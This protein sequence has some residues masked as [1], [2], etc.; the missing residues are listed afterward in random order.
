M[1]TTAALLLSLLTTSSSLGCD[2]LPPEHSPYGPSLDPGP[3]TPPSSTEGTIGIYVK[4]ELSRPGVADGLAGQT[5]AAY[6]VALSRYQILRSATDP[7]PA[8]CFDHGKNP[9]VAAMDG[10]DTLV[11]TCRTRSVP[12]GLYTHGRTKVDWARYSIDGVYHLGGQA[13]SGKFTFFRAFSDVTVASRSFRAGEGTV[14]FSTLGVEIPVVYPPLTSVP[15]LRFETLAGELSMTF[16][17]SNPL[18]ILESDQH[19]HWARFHW[20]VQ[21]GFRWVDASLPGYQPAVW[22]VSPL[23]A[24]T[25]MLYGVWSYFTTSSVD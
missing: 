4:G 25:V 19:Q 23:S 24:E 10:G 18:P 13:W 3:S 15:G 12:T 14:R 9:V 8:L 17:Y 1:R 6:E 16:A 22:D 20:M 5:P 7:S 2:P 21:D 11:G